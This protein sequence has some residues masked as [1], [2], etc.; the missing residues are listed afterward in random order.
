MANPSWTSIEWTALGAVLAGAG[1]VLGALTIIAAAW[2]GSRT[3]ESWRRQTLSQRRIEQ[4]ERI[5][6]ATYKVRRGLSHV[7]NPFLWAHELQAAEDYLKEKGQLTVGETGNRK[8]TT[9][10]LYYSRLNAELDNRRALEECQ[11]MARALFG[12]EVEMAMEELNRQ[13]HFVNNAVGAQYRFE[14]A[15]DR[16]FREEIEATLWGGTPK[17]EENKMD[18]NIAELVKV[19][20]GVCVPVLRL[21]K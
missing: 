18:R 9:A 16:K 2:F 12:E 13:F 1:T 6:T 3:F 11:P 14:E 15:T 4:A 20:E 5:L 8:L 7:R 17:P 19:I 10:Q 21:E